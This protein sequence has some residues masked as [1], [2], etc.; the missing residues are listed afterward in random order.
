MEFAILG[1]AKSTASRAAAKR[2]QAALVTLGKVVKSKQKPIKVDGALGPQT[3]AAV[4]WAF[5]HHIGAGQ[6][7]AQYRTGNL[8]LSQVKSMV[9]TLSD[10]IERE[11]ARRGAKAASPATV[12]KGQAIQTVQKTATI[13]ASPPASKADVK[14]L[15]SALVTL[16]KT[17]VSAQLKAIKVDG[18]LGPKT[19]AAVNWAF[20][21]HIGS[22]QAPAGV[23]T[24]NLT[25]EYVKGHAPT[26]SS[27]IEAEIK[28]RGAKATTE[29][30][31]SAATSPAKKA[32]KAT[33][34]G[35]QTALVALSRAVGS[36][37]KEITIDGALGP[38]TVAAV[39]WAFT[40]H[41]GAGQ[42]PTQ[43][44]TGNLTLNDVSA[45]ADTLTNLVNA[46]TRRRGKSTVVTV[47]KKTVAKKIAAK[48]ATTSTIVR[49]DSGKTVKATKVTTTSGETYKVE[50][51]STGK[52]TY[53]DDPTKDAAPATASPAAA[54]AEAVESGMMPSA[55]FPSM[56]PSESFFSQYKWPIIGAGV[57]VLGI[58]AVLALR[59]PGGG[60]AMPR[61]APRPAARRTR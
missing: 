24:G 45:H 10:L 28:R 43:F 27:L 35:L 33:V 44:R 8:T 3:V 31:K 21:H 39:N 59:R 16:G 48:P 52:V 61:S 25:L 32:D 4:N 53:T 55:A 17:V 49:T 41:L 42:A 9:N 57:A 58:G 37:Q 22:G 18:A 36:K 46:E 23:R 29:A 51:L 47:A 6:A 7:P 34:K 11:I 56:M 26:L 12:T 5:T 38:K 50:D 13:P 30:G 2:L 15:Q 14:R 54:E 19:V 20:T 1:A 40:H 60:G